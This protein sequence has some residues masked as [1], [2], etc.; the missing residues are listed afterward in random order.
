MA[1]FNNYPYTDF[2]EMNLDWV[3]KILKEMDARIDELKDEILREAI[4]A[5]EEYVDDKLADVL[6]EFADLKSDFMVLQSNFN[7]LNADFIQLRD[8]TQNKLTQLENDIINAVIGI[9]QRTDLLLQNM[10]DQ[11]FSDLSTQL[12]QIKVIN[13][14]T[15]ESVSV[16]DMFNYLAMLHLNDSIDYDTMAYRAKTYTQ[17]ASLNI[18]FENLIAHGNTLY[19]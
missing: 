3:L 2:H 19:V 5:T 6:S 1:I 10:Y 15:G 11:I 7:S 12:S 8:E 4:E 16:Q 13:Y 14:F 18:N 17:L 9:N